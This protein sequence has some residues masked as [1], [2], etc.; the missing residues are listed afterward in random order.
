MQMDS[1]S[2]ET[3]YRAYTRSEVNCN[4]ACLPEA[5]RTAF[6]SARDHSKTL[7]TG[8]YVYVYSAVNVAQILLSWQ[9]LVNELIKGEVVSPLTRSTVSGHERGSSILGGKINWENGQLIQF[10]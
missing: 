9:K 1:G 5:T 7:I 8:L 2:W 3:C 10:T 6:I 4:T